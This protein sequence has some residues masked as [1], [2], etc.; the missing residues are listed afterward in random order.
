MPTNPYYLTFGGNALTIGAGGVAVSTNP[1]VDPYNPLGLPP[2][3][4]RCKFSAGYT[5]A[6]GTLKTL[7]DAA[8]NIWDITEH[9]SWN[10][11]FYDN[12]NLLEVLGANTTGRTTM[13]YTFTECTSLT[14]VPLFDTSSVTSMKSLFSNCQLLTSIPLYDTS[15]V[16]DMSGMI[17]E[18]PLLTGVPLFDT[19]AATD[20]SN[21][22]YGCTGL[23]TVPLFDTSSV[24]NMR[25]MLQECSSL[26]SIPLFD[27]SSV[28]DMTTMCFKCTSVE[29]GALALYQ[30]A[31]SQ[32]S[33]P[34][35]QWT[36][37]NCGSGTV[38]GAQELS[39]IPSGWK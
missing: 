25:S 19:S 27:T 24:T 20:M 16:T 3:T 31:S 17:R 26:T 36:F 30:Q 12:N 33:I 23:I 18:C 13:E 22:F 37:T 10:A 29:T 35:H 5:P 21:M 2:D 14:S 1:V 38:S 15:S 34:T 39:Q 4:I 28:T 7:V 9:D 8:E 11:L 32:A 6:R